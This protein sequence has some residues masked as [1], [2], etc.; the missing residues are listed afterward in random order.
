MEFLSGGW[1]AS[2]I[3]AAVRCADGYSGAPDVVCVPSWHG[4]GIVWET[5]R[6]TLSGCAHVP[7]PVQF[8]WA[9]A[10][11]VSGSSLSFWDMNW[12]S[13]MKLTL[14]PT[15][16]PSLAAMNSLKN[17]ANTLMFDDCT[18]V[19]AGGS[20]T[21]DAGGSCFLLMVGEHDPTFIIDT[22]GLSGIVLY[23]QY[24][25]NW[26]RL[27][28]SHGVEIEPVAQARACQLDCLQEFERIESATDQAEATGTL[29]TAVYLSLI[30]I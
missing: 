16:T 18:E 11:G 25:S 6:A 15:D 9:G 29:C 26:F 4:N 22:T 30:H 5:N 24:L 8:A 27:S 19:E 28:D 21:P 20:M 3:R 12:I 10:F 23:A 17:Q 14:I 7:S 1:T 13:H 2:E